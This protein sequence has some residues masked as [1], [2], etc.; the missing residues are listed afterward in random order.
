[1]NA[2]TNDWT[3]VASVQGGEILIKTEG[4][5]VV[6]SFPSSVPTADLEKILNDQN[7]KF[8]QWSAQYHQGESPDETVA[9]WDLG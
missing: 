5:K 1:M 3:T 2:L 8:D 4:K 7:I 6:L 9:T